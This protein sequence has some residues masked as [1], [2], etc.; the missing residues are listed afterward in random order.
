MIKKR[1]RERS[2]YKLNPLLSYWKSCLCLLNFKETMRIYLCQHL[3]LQMAFVPFFAST[4]L[5]FLRCYKTSL[6]SASLVLLRD[7]VLLL[8]GVIPYFTSNLFRLS[9]QWL[10]SLLIHGVLD[11]TLTFTKEEHR[12]Y[13]A[14]RLLSKG[15]YWLSKMGPY[16]PFSKTSSLFFCSDM[17]NCL[18]CDEMSCLCNIK[19]Q[20][21]H[22]IRSFLLPVFSLAGSV[23]FV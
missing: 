22:H 7:R 14:R 17:L 21:W 19:E 10:D 18:V 11:W 6:W 1:Q 5:S 9:L 20:I 15:S 2:Q 16:F 13:T 3:G 23:P 8:K 4:N 12:V